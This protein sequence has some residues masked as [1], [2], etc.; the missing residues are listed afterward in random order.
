MQLRLDNDAASA[1]LLTL[2][3]L[4]AGWTS[5]Q[6]GASSSDS[7][8]EKA[9]ADKFASCLGVNPAMFD[10]S[11][12]ADTTKAKTDKFKG[13]PNLDV[14]QTV[15]V[16]ASKSDVSD[17]LNA[18]SKP[19]AAGCFQ[20]FFRAV[21]EYGLA[22]PDP[23]KELPKGFTVGDVT[24]EALNLKGGAAG[25]AAFRAT[26]PITVQKV[27]VKLVSDSVFTGTGRTETTLTFDSI[28]DSFPDALEKQLVDIAVG[29]L[30]D[31]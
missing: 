25:I 15:N 3:D 9:A 29:R 6:R 16:E 11:A 24:V 19:A 12:P 21:A 2:S 7:P 17:G 1:A 23:G 20:T 5:T 26:I 8:E 31:L 27:T 30:P 18:L 28:N 4:P 14:E 10:D 13:A 22:H